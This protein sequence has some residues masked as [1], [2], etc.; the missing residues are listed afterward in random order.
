MARITAAIT[1]S[2][3]TD[4]RSRRTSSS[5]VGVVVPA[6]V[7]A[8]VVERFP[9][10][11]GT[12]PAG[13]DRRTTTPTSDRQRAPSTD[14]STVDVL[15]VGRVVAEP[16]VHHLAAE[17]GGH[18]QRREHDQLGDQ[19]ASVVGALERVDAARPAATPGNRRTRSGPRRAPS[20]SAEYRG[21]TA[22]ISSA[23]PFGQ[24]PRCTARRDRPAST[25]SRRRAPCRPGS[26]ARSG[27]RWPRAPRGRASPRAR[28][29]RGRRR[30][31]TMRAAG[32]SCPSS[33]RCSSSRSSGNATTSSAEPHQRDVPVAGVE[34][35]RGTPSGR[36]P[37]S[38]A[39]RPRTRPRARCPARWSTATPIQPAHTT[40]GGAPVVATARATPRPGTRRRR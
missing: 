9:C 4:R 7:V 33:R 16:A 37:W 24:R 36:R 20:A 10:R 25:P 5:S 35:R 22:R 14:S 39:A 32:C 30:P 21:S 2:M 27:C 15:V 18:D 1:T 8:V 6:A 13:A 12:E 34:R 40:T 28:G 3:S 11:S 38:A 23:S 17:R 26:R 31:S 19:E 29:R